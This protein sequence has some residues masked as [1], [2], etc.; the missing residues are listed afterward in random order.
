MSGT[1][2]DLITSYLEIRRSL[3]FKL[4]GTGRLLH[5]FADWLDE[6]G[7]AAVT[8]EDTVAF[9]T[10]PAGASP[11]TQ[12]LRLSAIRCFTR[13]ASQLDPAIQVPPARLLPARPTRAAPWIYTPAQVT[14]L[15]DA[16]AAL[17]PALRA[18]TYRTL[19]GLM[20]S[21]GIRTGEALGIDT[22]DFDG[23]A[24]V[25]TVTGKYGK[26]REL[27]LHPSVAAALTAYLRERG[28]HPR[29]ASCPA[30]LV[31]GR[32]TRLIK[33]DVHQVFRALTSTAGLVPASAACRP[34]LHDFRHTLAVSVMLDAYNSGAD[35]AATLPV[36]ATW[37][38]HADP[39]DT[40]WYL[41]GTAELLA[42]ATARIQAG[43]GPG[44]EGGR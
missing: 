12:A 21:T 18:A 20:A 3:G 11:R 6:R 43:Q 41:T 23:Q 38:G 27:P 35:P 36:L 42:A 37:L 44:R 5:G 17:R 10:A 8:V 7:A 19:I 31:S 26:T 16:A 15:L 32:G 13:W 29:A 25:L 4:E 22:G 2:R 14:A 24:G 39:G 30:L 1:L 28:Q 33:Q 9:A 40:Y 34:R